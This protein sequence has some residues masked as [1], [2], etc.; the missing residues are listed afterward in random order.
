MIQIIR[1]LRK[2]LGIDKNDASTSTIDFD[3]FKAQLDE[4]SLSLQREHE[5]EIKK[6][7]EI[8]RLAIELFIHSHTIEEKI[9]LLT[10]CIRLQTQMRLDMQSNALDEARQINQ[11]LLNEIFDDATSQFFKEL[12]AIDFLCK[13]IIHDDGKIDFKIKS[14]MSSITIHHDHISR[15]L[16]IPTY[17]SFIDYIDMDRNWMIYHPT[18]GSMSAASS[19]DALK[20]QFEIDAASL[21]EKAKLEACMTPEAEV[22]KATKKQKI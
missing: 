19:A 3:S 4:I 10:S 15:F 8:K 13:P 5:E 14:F 17:Q 11:H 22:P 1:K 16:E 20:K 6:L 2:I 9:N 18:C 21:C 7:I 12:I